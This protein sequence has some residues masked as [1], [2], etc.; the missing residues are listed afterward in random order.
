MKRTYEP[1]SFG[2]HEALHMTS[3]L[4]DSVDEELVEHPSI[5]ANEEW[6]RLATVALDALNDLYQ[7]IGQKHL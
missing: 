4:I 2:C 6:T 5:K 3:F 7:A 1:G